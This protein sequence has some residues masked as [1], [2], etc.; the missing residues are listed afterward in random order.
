MLHFRTYRF[1]IANMIQLLSWTS[2][3]EKRTCPKK[4]FRYSSA[5]HLIFSQDYSLDFWEWG[6]GGGWVLE[7][8]TMWTVLR[9]SNAVTYPPKST[10]MT[11]KIHHTNPR[12]QENLTMSCWSP[13]YLGSG[14]GSFALNLKSKYYF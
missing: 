5:P 2:D 4:W 8:T 3:P 7:E 12:S 13:G 1:F 6:G 10:T 9:R 14:V 11:A